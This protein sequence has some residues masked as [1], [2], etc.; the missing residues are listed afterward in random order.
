MC[1]RW[2]RDGAH[3]AEYTVLRAEYIVL[4]AEYI[5]LRCGL[6]VL[7]LYSTH[8]AEYIVLQRVI[9]VLCL[10]STHR[11]EFIVL[12]RGFRCTSV[13]L[14]RFTHDGQVRCTVWYSLMYFACTLHCTGVHVL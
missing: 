6:G 9:D 14:H 11:A 10:Y 4:R 12:Q 8:R 7:C 2:G 13:V 3:R 5:V 1:G